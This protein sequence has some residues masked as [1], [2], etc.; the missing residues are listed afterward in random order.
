[1]C[2]RSNLEL[3]ELLAARPARMQ[4][5]NLLM[6]KRLY[7]YAGRSSVDFSTRKQTE[8]VFIPY[9]SQLHVETERLQRVYGRACFIHA[10]G[11]TIHHELPSSVQ[12]PAIPSV[13]RLFRFWQKW[14]SVLTRL[15]ELP[16][17]HLLRSDREAE[18]YGLAAAE[19]PSPIDED[20]RRL[21]T[22]AIL[23]CNGTLAGPQS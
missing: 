8:L 1:M 13:A 5:I 14:E 17:C 2:K 12:L 7:D 20:I 18:A 11:L 10:I 23:V 19:F 21:G 22:L 6:H 4:A 3:E 16:A 9:S 15:R